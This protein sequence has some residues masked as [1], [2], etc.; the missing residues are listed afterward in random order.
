MTLCKRY[1]TQRRST[2]FSSSVAVLIQKYRIDKQTMV[3]VY[4]KRLPRQR[5]GSS[6][7]QRC[8]EHAAFYCD[9]HSLTDNDPLGDSPLP[10]ALLLLQVLQRPACCLVA[11]AVASTLVVCM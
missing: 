11:A 9:A 7:L 1:S 2:H 3:E 5:Q 10:G 8:T 6:V 4:C